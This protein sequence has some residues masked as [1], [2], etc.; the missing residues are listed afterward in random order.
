LFAKKLPGVDMI[1]LGPN[2]HDVHSPDERVSISSVERVW[3]FLLMA[4]E[5]I[6][7]N[8]PNERSEKEG[9]ARVHNP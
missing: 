5:E 4:L 7:A 9:D 6:G 8:A 1:S 2:I 3:G